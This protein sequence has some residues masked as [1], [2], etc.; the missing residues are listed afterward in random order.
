[1]TPIG[2][3]NLYGTNYWNALIFVISSSGN[4]DDSSVYNTTCFKPVINLK[5][6][7]TITGKG[8]MTDPYIVN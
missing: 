2:G 5:S 8:T 1:M 6:N 3:Y 4:F 7:V